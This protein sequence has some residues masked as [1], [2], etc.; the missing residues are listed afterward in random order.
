MLGDDDSRMYIKRLIK[1]RLL[2]T[3]G[4]PREIRAGKLRSTPHLPPL[5]R[6]PQPP[7]TR[8]PTF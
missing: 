7:V 6:Q 4:F 1:S 5:H 2:K 8:R 3:E